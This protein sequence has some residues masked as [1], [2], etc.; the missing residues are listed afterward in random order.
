MFC[1]FY[2]KFKKKLQSDLY[3]RTK[4]VTAS[5][6][7]VFTKTMEKKN[8]KSHDFNRRFYFLN[9]SLELF[10]SNFDL[11]SSLK[12]QKVAQFVR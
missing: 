4:K 8:Q 7:L 1:N 11:R 10:F 6:H 3:Q 5:F 9:T 2:G 12:A